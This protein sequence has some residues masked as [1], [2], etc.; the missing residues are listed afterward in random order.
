[1]PLWA[2][3]P[4]TP[5]SGVACAGVV[6]AAGVCCA[7]GMTLWC[8]FS[9]RGLRGRQLARPW[10][11]ARAFPGPGRTGRSLNFNSPPLL[12][13]T[14]AVV[15]LKVLCHGAD[16]L[17]RPF[18]CEDCGAGSW[19]GHGGRPGPFPGRASPTALPSV[20]PLVRAVRCQAIVP[21]EIAPSAGPAAPVG[22]TSRAR[23]SETYHRAGGGHLRR[24][25]QLVPAGP[26]V[27]AELTLWRDHGGDSVQGG[28]RRQCGGVLPVLGGPCESGSGPVEPVGR[29]S[30]EESKR[31]LRGGLT[32]PCGRVVPPV[33]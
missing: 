14:A 9:V 20:L 5:R 19:P 4:G 33:M 1:M 25:R 15:L 28:S 10:R 32:P 29:A 16:S 8:A 11:Q 12:L 6:G 21:E 3:L 24:G 22:L 13:G 23:T 17:V 2:A 30:R 27:P 7:M 31:S 26:A 18:L